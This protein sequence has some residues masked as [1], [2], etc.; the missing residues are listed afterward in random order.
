MALERD[1]NDTHVLLQLQLRRFTNLRSLRLLSDASFEKPAHIAAVAAKLSTL[2][3]WFHERLVPD[4]MQ[5]ALAA[6]T[7]LED[8]GI[9]AMW[10]GNLDAVCRSLRALTHTKP[11]WERAACAGPG[12]RCPPEPILAPDRRLSLSLFRCTHAHAAA[13]VSMLGA[14]PSACLVDLT[15]NSLGDEYE[16]PTNPHNCDWVSLPPLAHLPIQLTELRLA[17]A[18]SLPPDWTQLQHLETL[19]VHMER[20]WGAEQVQQLEVGRSWGGFSWGSAP[21]TA[22]TQLKTLVFGGL[23]PVL[24][25]K[26]AGLQCASACCRRLNKA[27]LLRMQ[28]R[29]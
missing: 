2:R 17:G 16:L 29:P 20:G 11:W 1:S 23:N 6:A 14:L 26:R 24:P 8:L 19:E 25:G 7:Q 3:L 5:H 10:D 27:L 12:R 28:T 22:L 21:L 9:S 13:A 4:D 18:V 15:I